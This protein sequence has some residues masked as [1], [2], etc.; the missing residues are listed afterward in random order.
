MDTIQTQRVGDHGAALLEPGNDQ[1]LRI[2][3]S[4]HVARPELPGIQGEQRERPAAHAGHRDWV[5][6]CGF[7]ADMSSAIGRK[8]CVGYGADNVEVIRTEKEPTRFATAQRGACRIVGGVHF[9]EGEDLCFGRTAD[10]PHE[11]GDQR[12]DD[13]SHC[14]FLPASVHERDDFANMHEK[15]IANE[16]PARSK[17][18]FRTLCRRPLCCGTYAHQ[19]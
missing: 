8:Q 5:A 15:I 18:R 16:K 13:C 2:R 9:V 1:R 11:Y 19:H 14:D 6:T 3:M 7:V 12:G 10:A 17:R 4:R